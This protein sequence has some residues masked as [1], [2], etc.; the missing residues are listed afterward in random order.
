MGIGTLAIFGIS[1]NQ[2]G[3]CAIFAGAFG[4]LANAGIG[5]YQV[6]IEKG[7][8]AAPSMCKKAVLGSKGLSLEQLTEQIMNNPI[9]S[10]DEVAWS[11]FGISFAGYSVMYSLLMGLA[12]LVLGV[13]IYGQERIA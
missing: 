11:L 1:L 10:C 2:Y 8:L 13:L 3:L 9:V 12:C 6:M 4:Y 5:T 7:I